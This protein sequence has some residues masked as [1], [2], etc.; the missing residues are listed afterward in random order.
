LMER[1]MGGIRW[2]LEKWAAGFVRDGRNAEGRESMTRVVL[3]MA[4]QSPP[5]A[6]EKPA[7]WARQ[8]VTDPAYQL[9]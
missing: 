4:P 6:T 5:A 3:A 9:K 8:L 7:D 1:Q 2:N